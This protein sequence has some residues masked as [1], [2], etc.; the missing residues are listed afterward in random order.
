ML[1]NRCHHT[2][3]WMCVRK[4]ETSKRAATNSPKKQQSII[5]IRLMSAWGQSRLRKE[6][7]RWEM[8]EKEKH[9]IKFY[10]WGWEGKNHNKKIW[11]K[12]FHSRHQYLPVT[13][14]PT[15]VSFHISTLYCFYNFEIEQWWRQVCS[16]LKGMVRF[17]WNFFMTLKKQ[18]HFLFME[19][20]ALTHKNFKLFFKKIL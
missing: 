15:T 5:L 18:F 17:F 13:L 2:Y 10:C 12:K 19:K 1:F 6:K 9:D 14:L 8:D 3:G 7:A 20:I 16:F 4:F 11:N